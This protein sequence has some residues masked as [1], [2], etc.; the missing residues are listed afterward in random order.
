MKRR[1]KRNHKVTGA[2]LR[3]RNIMAEEYQFSE[4]IADS[5]DSYL[6]E[7]LAKYKDIQVF[8]D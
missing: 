3:K 6:S 7:E 5:R 8:Y 4:V 1:Q 2:S